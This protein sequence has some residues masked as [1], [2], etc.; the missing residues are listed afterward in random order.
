MYLC[1]LILHGLRVVSSNVSGNATAS[2]DRIDRQD[3]A[4]CL[5]KMTIFLLLVT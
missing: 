2:K 4:F 3:R 1:S 5:D